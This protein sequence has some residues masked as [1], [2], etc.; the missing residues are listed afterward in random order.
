MIDLLVDDGDLSLDTQQL[1]TEHPPIVLIGKTPKRNPLGLSHPLE[2]RFGWSI[3]MLH[4]PRVDRI[5][6]QL[7]EIAEQREN[8]SSRNEPTS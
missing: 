1:L 8:D 2:E 3:G 7:P 5:V 4:L 6:G